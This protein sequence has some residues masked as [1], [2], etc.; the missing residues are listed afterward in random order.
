MLTNFI[1]QYFKTYLKKRITDSVDALHLMKYDRYDRGANSYVLPTISPARAEARESAL[2]I[3]RGYLDREA[4][5]GHTTGS[6]VDNRFR[7][8]LGDDELIARGYKEATA[9]E[10]KTQVA[11][12]PSKAEISE[13]IY[14]GGD[15]GVYMGGVS[16]EG[17]YLVLPDGDEDLFNR[18]P[19]GTPFI[20]T[21]PN[22]GKRKTGRK[23]G[24]AK[25][26][27]STS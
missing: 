20:A 26:K 22:T 9:E 16:Y 7:D 25:A 18:L 14:S 19:P 3:I 15:A 10:I 21:D 2:P 27:A 24:N 8:L 5:L 4:E 12:A 1:P 23:V 6:I 13:A 11:P 17:E